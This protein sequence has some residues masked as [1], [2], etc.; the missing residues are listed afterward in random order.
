MSLISMSAA[1]DNSD[2]FKHP[3]GELLLGNC[4]K[5]LQA[6]PNGTFDFLLTDPPYGVNYKDRLDRS[7][8]GDNDLGWLQPAF[9]EIYRVLRPNSFAISFY[10]YG[11]ADVLLSTWKQVGFRI[12]GHFTFEKHY[13]SNRNRVG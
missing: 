2:T 7:L 8:L 1:N 12:V 10:G 3:N 6:I 9:E 4:I 5:R 11:D 13:A